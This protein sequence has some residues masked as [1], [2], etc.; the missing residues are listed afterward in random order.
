VAFGFSGGPEDDAVT[1]LHGQTESEHHWVPRRTLASLA[2]TEPW[3]LP[4]YVWCETQ[5]TLQGREAG[6]MKP[7]AFSQSDRL[8]MKFML[9]AHSVLWCLPQ[10]RE[11]PSGDV[12][13]LSDMR[14]S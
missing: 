6:V 8:P 5:V 1:P 2:P 14:P 13:N 11:A 9:D 7:H 10:G 4:W 3:W 12:V